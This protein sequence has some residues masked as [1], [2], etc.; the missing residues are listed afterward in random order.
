MSSDLA[1][2]IT[3]PAADQV[4]FVVRDMDAALALYAPLFGEFTQ[5]EAPV[6]D[7]D[8]R[9]EKADCVLK[10]AFAK[11]GELEIELIQWVSGPCPHQEFLESGREGMHHL[12]FR[13]DNV[14]TKAAE[15][16]ALGYVP[17]WLKRMSPEIAWVYLERPGDPLIIE[18]LQMPE[19]S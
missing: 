3:L 1:K 15:A 11:S 10:I 16:A 6:P 5:M 12:R 9:G 19:M 17:I 13:V 7:A 2:A 18:F 8:F 4:G 14:D